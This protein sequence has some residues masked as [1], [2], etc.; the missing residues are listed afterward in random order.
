[1]SVKTFV[2]R[3]AAILPKDRVL[4]DRFSRTIFGAD[5]SPYQLLPE[6]VV[7]VDNEAEVADLCKVASNTGTAITFRAAGTSLSGQAVT[8]SVLVK[9]SATGWRKFEQRD[10]GHAVCVGPGLVGGHVNARLAASNRKIGP[11]PASLATAMMGG[12]A[13]NNSSGMCCGTAF[14][15]YQTLRSL[16]VVLADGSTLDTG[17]DESRAAFTQSHSSL[18]TELSKLAA[19]VRSDPGLVSMIKHKYAIKN[20]IGYQLNAFVDF[21]D[22]Y[23]ILAHL[24]VGSE[25][26]LGFIS[27]LTLDTVEDPPNKSAALVFYADMDAACSAA[28]ALKTSPVSAV[29]FMDYPSLLSVKGRPGVPAEIDQLPVGTSALLVDVRGAT[30]AAL[31]ANVSSVMSVLGEYR[32]TYPVRFASDRTTYEKHWNVRKGLLPAV[33]GERP[34]GTTVIVEDVAVPLDKLALAATDLRRLFDRLGYSTAVIFGHALDGNLHIVFPQGFD[35]EAE[36]ARYAELVDTMAALVIERYQGSLKAEHGTGRAMAPFVEL[37]WGATA[38]AL[39]K[40]IKSTFDPHGVLNP[41]VIISQDAEIHLKHMKQLPPTDPLIDKCIECGFCEPVCPS[42]ALTTTPRQRIVATRALSAEQ[43]TDPAFSKSYRYSAIDTCA[44]DGLCAGRCPVGIDTGAMM[45]QKREERHGRLGRRSAA[46]I[47]N[48]IGAA[49]SVARLALGTACGTR[50]IIG[51][52]A[53]R[54]ISE[55]LRSVTGGRTPRWTKFMPRAG[56]KP[57]NSQAGDERPRVVLFTSCVS[58]VMGPARAAPDE[59]PLWSCM[60]SLLSKAGYDPVILTAADSACCGMPFKSKGF[61]AQAQSSMETLEATLLKASRGGIDPVICD[62]SPCTQQMLSSLKGSITVIDVV[63]ALATLVVP[64]VEIARKASSV[65]LHITCSSRKMGHASM[66]QHLAAACADRVTVPQE[67]ECCGFA[68]DK[69]FN[70]PELNASALRTLRS[71]LPADCSVG[72]SSSRT[73]EI[74]L[75]THS[76]RHYQSIAY[77]LDWCTEAIAPQDYA[78]QAP[79]IASIS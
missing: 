21:D 34:A 13:A 12:I 76:D 28:T 1:M 23:D 22:P 55:G 19:E 42:R 69:G 40:R 57:H 48:H 44:G 38:Y 30:V 60:E 41:N 65:A 79:A 39:M 59:R 78:S 31:E 49:S 4:T 71:Q 51:D 58:S 29:E 5:A 46:V 25:G 33:G 77:L 75:S 43:H 70:V 15:T 68:G 17:S 18:L 56:A 2:E 63:E 61:P 37:E 20:T 3:L 36:V 7:I 67:I 53:M 35:S 64:R 24:M 62:T 16:R 72:Y 6:A 54:G 52:T 66:L 26:T 10:G 73:C 27:E 45:R 11:D 9:L 14:N 50:D 47:E 74:G 8:D 32:P